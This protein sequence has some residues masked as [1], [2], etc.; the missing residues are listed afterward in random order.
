[1]GIHYTGCCGAAGNSPLLIQPQVLL[2]ADP[3]GWF[4]DGTGVETGDAIVRLVGYEVDERTDASIPPEISDLTLLT[5]SPYV[6]SSGATR[7]G[8]TA[9]L[10]SAASG[11]YVFAAGTMSWSYALAR[12]DREPQP[13]TNGDPVDAN[14][15]LQL[16]T[17]N[18]LDR[19]LESPAPVPEPGFGLG[20]GW[21]AALL[22]LTCRPRKRAGRARITSLRGQVN[23][24]RRN[25][26]KNQ[27]RKS[28]IENC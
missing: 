7:A 9:L 25:P 2:G 22:G 12:D 5:D 8:Q 23:L 15:G 18:L 27:V 1:M 14:R 10:R 6:I 11:A 28:D 3:R 24:E 26:G 16:A 20:A 21:G 17:I 13:S 19:F 4:W